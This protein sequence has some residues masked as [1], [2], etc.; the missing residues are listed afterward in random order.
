MLL[1]GK[2]I[3]IVEDNLENRT[4]FQMTLLRYGVLID[5]ERRGQDTITRLSNLPRVDLI[6]LDLQ[7]A[8]GLSGFDLYDEIRAMPAYKDVPIIAVSAMDASVAVPQARTKGFSGFITKPIDKHLFPKQL[9]DIFD[10]KQV[11]YVGD[12]GRTT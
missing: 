8:E 7:L 5:F 6:I 4:I 11:W 9:S 2:S 10:G 12:R 3:F 1:S